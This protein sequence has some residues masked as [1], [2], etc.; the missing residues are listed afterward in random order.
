MHMNFTMNI[1]GL[2]GVTIL[3]VEQVEETMRVY[4]EM[5]RSLQQCPDCGAP[6]SRVHD[7]RIQKVK[8]LKWFERKTDLFYKRRRYV[9]ACGKRFSEQ[10]PFVQRYQRTSIE[11]NQAVGIRAIKGKTFKETGETYGSSSSTIVRRFDRLARSEIRSVEKLPSVIAIDEYKGDTREGKYQLIIADGIT[12][13]PLDILPNRYKNTIKHYLQKYGDQVQVVIM[14]MSHSFK[15]AVQSALGRPVIVAD[16]F[17]FC[18]YIYWALDG[19]RR[20]VQKEFHPYDRKKCKRMKHVFH[21][22][23]DRLT[24]EDRWHLNRYLDMS[25]ELKKAYELKETYRGWFVQAKESGSEDVGKVKTGLRD[26]Y[27]LVQD[28]GIP[29][30]AKAIATLQNWQTEILNSFVYGYSNGFLEGINN[31]TKVLKRN[32]YGFRNFSRFRAKILLTH[33]FKGIGIHIG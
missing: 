19:V 27:R 10:N 5:E 16:R 21:K 1:P 3:K 29:E 26:F 8:H 22:A 24:E 4:V 2:E 9:C 14:D 31:S 33:Q 11:W 7:Y 13:K 20:R 25:E 15:S 12:K 30:M 18:R 28:S 32:A 23:S 6:T 17:H